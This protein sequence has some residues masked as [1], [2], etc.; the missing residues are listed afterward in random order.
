MIFRIIAIIITIVLIQSPGLASIR[1]LNRISQTEDELRTMESGPGTYVSARDLSRM[2][3]MR[4]PFL[5][6]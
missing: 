2:L 3:G 5:N 4:D 6:S 1:V